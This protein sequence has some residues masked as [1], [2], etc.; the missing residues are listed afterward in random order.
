MTEFDKFRCWNLRNME[1][2]GVVILREVSDWTG[3]KT[4]RPLV[5]LGSPLLVG[6][7]SFDETYL[8]FFLVRIK[9]SLKLFYF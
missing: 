6:T 1:E 7:K 2:F 5:K 9:A 3:Y 4:M 8:S